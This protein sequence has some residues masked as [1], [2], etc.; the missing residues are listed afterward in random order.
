MTY[1]SSNAQKIQF[2]NRKKQLDHLFCYLMV[3]M[4]KMSG[5]GTVGGGTDFL[6]DLGRPYLAHKISERFLRGGCGVW[7]SPIIRACQFPGRPGSPG[8]A[9]PD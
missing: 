8:S 5:L 6:L 9:T 2:S 1:C 4:L 7:G 3:I